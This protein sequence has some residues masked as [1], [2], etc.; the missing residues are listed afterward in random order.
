MV[1][2]VRPKIAVKEVKAIGSSLDA[3][4]SAIASSKLILVF[5]FAAIL[6][7]INIE[8]LTTIPK[9][10]NTPTRAGNDK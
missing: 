8:F 1:I 2:G 3:A 6:S 7:T 9:S 5:W 4:P 10:A